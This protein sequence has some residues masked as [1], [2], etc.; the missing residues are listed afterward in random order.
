MSLA[1]RMSGIV[2]TGHG[3]PEALAPPVAE[4]Y[5][6]ARHRDRPEECR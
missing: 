6:L 3:G 2:L 5:P 4:T 1:D